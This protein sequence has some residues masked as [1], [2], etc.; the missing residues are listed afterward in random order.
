LLKNSPRFARAQIDSDNVFDFSTDIYSFNERNASFYLEI[1][2]DLWDTPGN[3]CSG[4]G[5]TPASAYA[6]R[7]KITG[8][9]KVQKLG[10]CEEL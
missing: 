1:Y 3:H 4:F 5:V 8:L 7:V 2:L 6:E 9:F 10:G